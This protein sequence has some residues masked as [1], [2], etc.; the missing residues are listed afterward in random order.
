MRKLGIE[1]EI[2]FH[3]WDSTVSNEKY[4][5]W[6]LM[7]FKFYAYQVITQVI[8]YFS[9]EV[10]KYRSNW[11]LFSDCNCN[12]IWVLLSTC[13]GNCIQVPYSGLLQ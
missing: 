8:S 12:C 13:N 9:K 3:K 10:F 7:S 6:A 4:K 11:L 2:M 5:I 1:I